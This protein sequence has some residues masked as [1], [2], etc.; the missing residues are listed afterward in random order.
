MKTFD[1]VWKC[2]GDMSK[3]ELKK[4]GAWAFYNATG[5]EIATTKIDLLE[6]DG[7]SLWFKAGAVYFLNRGGAEQ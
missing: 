1:S 4:L 6:S 7:Y 2:I 5:C 3:A